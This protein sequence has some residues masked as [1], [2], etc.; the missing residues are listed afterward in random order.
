MLGDPLTTYFPVLLSN[1]WWGHGRPI[2]QSWRHL[3]RKRAR[4]EQSLQDILVNAQQ[5]E[6]NSIYKE[7][8]HEEMKEYISRRK[9]AK[10][11]A[12]LA[13]RIHGLR[14]NIPLDIMDTI[15]GYT[16]FS[17]K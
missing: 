3:M 5:M 2:T 13:I 7:I 6:K 11:K 1:Y 12:R 8:C 16:T 4:E 9:L 15:L 14:Q 10:H 17:Q